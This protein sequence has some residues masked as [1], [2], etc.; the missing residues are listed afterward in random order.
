[1][2]AEF[3]RY[4]KTYQFTKEAGEPPKTVRI[5]FQPCVLKPPFLL[6]LEWIGF[7]EMRAIE[8]Y[9]PVKEIR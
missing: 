5:P 4:G 7:D 3:T 8:L 1:M 6:E 9:R 2:T